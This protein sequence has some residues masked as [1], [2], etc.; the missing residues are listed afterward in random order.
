MIVYISASKA[1]KY[2]TQLGLHLSEEADIT[3][4]NKRNFHRSN[5]SDTIPC[6]YTDKTQ[7]FISEQVF[8]TVHQA[9]IERRIRGQVMQALLHTDMA[10]ALLQFLPWDPDLA[11][12]VHSA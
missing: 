1:Q 7:L 6:I 4:T 9:S 11:Y 2:T 5:N 10:F 3:S 8:Q 12:P